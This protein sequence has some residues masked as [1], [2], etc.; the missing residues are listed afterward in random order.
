[1][2]PVSSLEE[3][4]SSSMVLPRVV[5]PMLGMEVVVFRRFSSIYSCSVVA[6]VLPPW[7]E[8]RSV[9]RAVAVTVVQSGMGMSH[10]SM[11]HTKVGRGLRYC[12]HLGVDCL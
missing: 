7:K 12:Q 6:V 11:F 4:L 10:V 9:E 3:L 2:K 1:M 8:G 5:S